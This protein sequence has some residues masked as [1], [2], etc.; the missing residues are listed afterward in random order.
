[1]HRTPQLSSTHCT[2]WHSI[3]CALRPKFIASVTQK[4][5]ESDWRQNTS[6]DAQRPYYS[7]KGVNLNTKIAKSQPFSRY[8][9]KTPPK[10]DTTRAKKQ[11]PITRQPL[12]ENRSV[13]GP[14]A[15]PES[16]ESNHPI[17]S[18]LP[19]IVLPKNAENT[20]RT[21][22]HRLS[23]IIGAH[24]RQPGPAFNPSQFREAAASPSVQSSQRSNLYHSTCSSSSLGATDGSPSRDYRLETGDPRCRHHHLPQ[25]VSRV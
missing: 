14:T 7:R 20:T 18:L 10:R 12:E 3:V 23:P 25:Q 17:G 13:R 1:M 2:T 24:K 5:D 22:K 8:G 21:A 9:Q 4:V 19:P 15:S 11:S 16:R 6:T